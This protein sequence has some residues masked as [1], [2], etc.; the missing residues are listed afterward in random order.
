MPLELST[1]SRVSHDSSGIIVRRVVLLHQLV[2]L[3]NSL[4]MVLTEFD[5]EHGAVRLAIVPSQGLVLVALRVTV[6]EQ[7]GHLLMRVEPVLAECISHHNLAY[8]VSELLFRALERPV[9]A[10]GNKPGLIF[11]VLLLQPV[12]RQ[13]RRDLRVSVL[14]RVLV[15]P[16]K[17]AQPVVLLVVGDCEDDLGLVKAV[18]LTLVEST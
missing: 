15:A 12:V 7:I 5:L 18:T 16:V 11:V 4:S 8:L 6:D 9:V 10:R 17:I 1:Q 13:L 2:V 14:H 3:S